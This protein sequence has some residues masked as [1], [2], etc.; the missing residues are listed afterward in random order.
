MEAEDSIR[1]DLDQLR[2]WR[3]ALRAL[4]P[5][6][7]AADALTA[8]PIEPVRGDVPSVAGD[9]EAEDSDAAAAAV[10]LAGWIDD[11]LNDISD[12]VKGTAD[13]WVETQRQIAELFRG[14]ADGA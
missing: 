8:S 10:R 11:E 13:E 14:L 7:P 3:E 5:L 2:S 6:R 4:D 1:V 9:L 12:L